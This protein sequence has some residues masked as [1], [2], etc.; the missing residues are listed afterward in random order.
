MLTFVILLP[1]M[2]ILNAEVHLCLAY[3]DIH[4]YLHTVAFQS[5]SEVEMKMSIGARKRIR[6]Q[7]DEICLRDSAATA[8]A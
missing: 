3:S 6:I 8:A 1:E 7:R 5:F 4:M 2:H